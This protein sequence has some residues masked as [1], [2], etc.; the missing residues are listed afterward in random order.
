MHAEDCARVSLVD[1]VIMQ[2]CVRVSPWPR[3]AT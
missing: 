3:R 2:A 1:A